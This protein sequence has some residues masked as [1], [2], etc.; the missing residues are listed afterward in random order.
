LSSFES[1]NEA[2]LDEDVDLVCQSGRL[3]YLAAKPVTMMTKKAMIT[4]NKWSRRFDGMRHA[5]LPVTDK[6]CQY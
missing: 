2:Q 3:K 5:S 1:V 4:N 6:H